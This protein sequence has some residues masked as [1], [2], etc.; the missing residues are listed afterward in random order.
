MGNL[1]PV[2]EGSSGGQANIS[3]RAKE[4]PKKDDGPQAKEGYLPFH[5]DS[6]LGLRPGVEA[7]FLHQGG[8][9]FLLPAHRHDMDAV[10]AGHLP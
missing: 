8:D 7:G 5:V 2:V 4:Q 10:D 6:S 3:D 9:G 1:I